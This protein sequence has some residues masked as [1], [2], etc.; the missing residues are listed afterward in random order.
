MSKSPAEV[1]QQRTSNF[2]ANRAAYIK[3]TE[4][5]NEMEHSR[6]DSQLVGAFMAVTSPTNFNNICKALKE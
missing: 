4:N 2:A 6:F 3:L 1:A 5:L